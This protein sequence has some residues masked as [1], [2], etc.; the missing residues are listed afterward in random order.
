MNKYTEDSTSVTKIQKFCDTCGT[1]IKRDMACTVA[2]CEICGN[3]ICE[4]CIAH[5]DGSTGDYRTVY[6]AKCWERGVEYRKMITFHENMAE[7]LYETWMR[8]CLATNHDED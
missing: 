1:E 3:D 7:E 8:E 5:E 6:C 2:K 4:K